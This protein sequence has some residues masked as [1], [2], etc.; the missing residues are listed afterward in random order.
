VTVATKREHQ[1]SLLAPRASLRT[2]THDPSPVRD[3]I[4]ITVIG[5][6]ALTGIMLALGVL[7]TH[8]LQHS[9]GRWDEHV[10]HWFAAR[11]TTAWNDATGVATSAINTLPVVVAAALIV[12][13][14]SLRHRW[15]EAA[16]LTIAL[17]LEIT[18]FLSVT[19]V[20]ARPRPHVARLNSTPST[21]S[22][23]SGH[24]AAATVLFLGGAL[25]VYCCT[26]NTIARVLSVVVA[27]LAPILVGFGR[28]YRGL[29]HPTDVIVGF[30]YGVACLCIAALAVRRANTDTERRSAHDDHDDRDDRDTES[31][32]TDGRVPTPSR[33]AS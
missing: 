4:M 26:H 10:N 33:K 21:S 32:A 2:E 27:L 29:H 19:F 12:G 18:V 17:V 5:Y 24:T 15:R 3:A 16:F 11:R 13:V 1:A 22:F 23:P 6:V 31:N 7:L 8:V 14:L 25:I 20:V 28:V 9:V 30:A